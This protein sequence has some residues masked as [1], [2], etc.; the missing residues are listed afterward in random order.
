MRKKCISIILTLSMMFGSI[1]SWGLT[2]YSEE[3]PS[4]TAPATEAVP[5]DTTV[6][7][8]ETEP[9]ITETEAS[10]S[11]PVESDI[12]EDTTE[13]TD[14]DVTETPVVT[15]A[16]V[17]EPTTVTEVSDC[18]IRVAL[19]NNS[20][21]YGQNPPAFNTFDENGVPVNW[22]FEKYISENETWEPIELFSNDEAINK[23]LYKN[24]ALSFDNTVEKEQ[25]LVDEKGNKYALLRPV[26]VKYSEQDYMQL[27]DE[28]Y[29]YINTDSSVK[30]IFQ[31]ELVDENY[32]NCCIYNFYEPAFAPSVEC[33]FEAGANKV[34]LTAPHNFSI[35]SDVSGS[36]F[37]DSIEYIVDKQS[38]SVKY[39]LKN[40]NPD[41]KEEYQAETL[42]REISYSFD[43]TVPELSESVTYD[44]ETNSVLNFLSFG[45]FGN[46]ETKL[47]FKAYGGQ[48]EFL[49]SDDEDLTLNFVNLTNGNG[50]EITKVDLKATVDDAGVPV[51]NSAGQI[52]YVAYIDIMPE[53]QNAV[54]EAY[55][56]YDNN[57]S[58]A[59]KLIINKVK[60]GDQLLTLETVPVEIKIPDGFTG[61]FSSLQDE[62]SVE[63]KDNT[64]GLAEVNVYLDNSEQPSVKKTYNEKKNDDVL[65][66]TLKELSE[67]LTDGEHKFVIKAKDNSGNVE[68]EKTVD[69]FYDSVQPDVTVEKNTS[70]DKS[71]SDDKNFCT[72]GDTI[73]ITVNED[74]LS[75]CSLTING[76]KGD[77]QL[78]NGLAEILVTED[79]FKPGQENTIAVEAV[80]ISGSNDTDEYKFTY[81]NTEPEVKVNKDT[82]A[83][84]SEDINFCT[85]GD[86]VKISVNESNLKSA[87]YFVNGVKQD[88]QL[89][90]GD[91]AIKIGG[92]AYKSAEKNIIKV[93]A[94]DK[95][96]N[97][98]SAEY[99]FT[100]DDKKSDITVTLSKGDNSDANEIWYNSVDDKKIII[101]TLDDIADIKK[102]DVEVKR[103]D[104]SVWQNEN[105]E[106][107]NPY[108]VALK[109]VCGDN[110]Q[111]GQ[112]TVNVKVT[113]KAGND[114]VTEKY[115]N[116]DTIKPYVESIIF[117]TKDGTT[118][119]AREFI[120]ESFEYGYYFNTEDTLTAVVNV[121]D[122]APS[123][124]LKMMSYVLENYNT[125]KNTEGK[126]EIL[127]GKAS[128]EIPKGFKGQ[129][130]VSV[131]DNVGNT[132]EDVTPYGL[133]IDP[134][135]V[136]GS[137]ENHISFS[138]LPED[139]EY[140]DENNTPIYKTDDENNNPAVSL[141]VNVSD[142]ESGI[143]EIGYKILSSEKVLQEGTAI[144]E[145]NGSISDKSWIIDAEN[146]KDENL[147]TAVSRVF[148]FYDDGNDIQLVITMKDRAGNISELVS[149]K[150]IIDNTAPV[151]KVEFKDE[152][153]SHGEENYYKKSRKATITVTER[154]ISVEDII[155]EITNSSGSVP[156]Y[157]FKEVD[158]TCYEAEIVFNEGDYHFEVSYADFANNVATVLYSGGN[159]NDF[160]VDMTAPVVDISIAEDSKKPVEIDGKDWID[161]LNN[162]YSW[163]I[164]INEKNYSSIDFGNTFEEANFIPEITGNNGK[165]SLTVESNKLKENKGD[166]TYTIEATVKDKAG[167][168]V[169]LNPTVLHIDRNAPVIDEV[170]ADKCNVRPYGIF[171]NDNI[172]L[173]VK[174]ADGQNESGIAELK[175]IP[176]YEPDGRSF[177]GPDK[178]GYYNITIS[179]NLIEKMGYLNDE[180]S[181]EVVA[182][183]K[184][185][186]KSVID[187]DKEKHKSTYDQK[188]AAKKGGE[189]VAPCVL[190]IDK[191]D[192]L[193]YIN[194]SYGDNEDRGKGI[195]YRDILDKEMVI[196]PS[197]KHSGLNIVD[198]SVFK[199]NENGTKKKLSIPDTN[200]NY[201]SESE[202]IFEVDYVIELS[203]IFN[204]KPID[205][206]KYIVSVS[207]TDNAGNPINKT[208]E[209]NI[210]TVRPK[211]DSIDFSIKT[212]DGYESAEKYISK[213]EYGYYFKKDITV[214]VNVSD[215]D[216]SSGLWKIKDT[217]TDYSSGEG[218]VVEEEFRNVSEGNKVVFE[219]P[220]G[221]KGQISIAAFDNVGNASGVA[222]PQ[223]LIIDSPEKHASEQHIFFS[224]FEATPY[225]DANGNRLY[226]HGVVLTVTVV[227]DVSGIRQV[228]YEYNSENGGSSYSSI[229]IENTGYEVGQTLGD[230]WV[231]KKMDDNLVTEVSRTFSF[232][233]DGN[234]IWLRADMQDRSMN[235]SEDRSELFT[236]DMTAPVIS[237]VFDNP[238]GNG[239]YYS[240]NRTATVNVTERNFDAGRIIAD[241]TNSFGSTPSLSFSSN[242]ATEHTA[243][244]TFGEG[245]YT[246]SISGSD[247]ANHP[248][249]V[250][251]SG[252]NEQKFF[253]DLTDPTETDNFDQFINNLNNSFNVN[254]EMTIS[255]VEHNFQPDMVDL[256]IY[257]VPAGQSF[258]NGNRTECTSQYV[259]A[260][261]WNSSG[262]N[263]SISFTFEEDYIY[264]VSIGVTDASGRTL[265]AKN[266]PVFEIDKTVPVL[267]SPDDL[268]SIVY[269]K[270]DTKTKADP[271]V[272]NDSNIGSIN[273]EITAYQMLKN[274]VDGEIVGYDVEEHTYTEKIEGSTFT[275]NDKYFKTDG[276][277]EVKCIANDIA[278]N[279]SKQSV[280]TFIVQRDTDFLVYIPNSNKETGEGRYKFD[281]IGRRSD[282]FEDINIV[283]YI[284]AD[285]MFSVELDDNEVDEA[286]FEVNKDDKSINDVCKYD[287]IL[288]SNYISQNYGDEDAELDL[289]LNAFAYDKNA[290]SHGLPITL[291]HIHV[292][293]VKPAGDYESSMQ[294]LAWYDGFYGVNNKTLKIEGVSLDID[295]DNCEITANNDNLDFT[296]DENSHTISFT[297]GK[298]SHDVSAILRDKAGNEN[299]LAEKK[300]IYV[301]SVIDRFLALI[302]V[303]GII[304]I[305]API[306]SIIYIRK[307]RASN[308]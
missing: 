31:Q 192:P 258:N 40:N 194:L 43:R 197:D 233:A 263:H 246:F 159:E 91:T 203:T 276:I 132:Q 196:T 209:F 223:G 188:V 56:S 216:P 9:V 254:K 101:E 148:D 180:I 158:S 80:D 293:N 295:A 168:T 260:G 225:S 86:T 122:N 289:I 288:K 124:G 100:Y 68:S 13:V 231:V 285:K 67:G 7:P 97:V 193:V 85:N 21:Y 94:V 84:K 34:K 273:C 75:S 128:F 277:Y 172:T 267:Q 149:D 90:N 183:D 17:E 242:S 307:R 218:I 93:E 1:P 62:I 300:N 83:S 106:M 266:S 32:K 5:D 272:F 189:K 171:R 147:V 253:V 261:Q 206:G 46:K 95:S 28:E 154:N 264:Q 239:E 202:A 50:Q 20:L 184:F 3:I 207:V 265:A 11:A 129:V 110:L 134:P 88:K 14:T 79:K 226:D 301:G 116:V 157:E 211:V 151:I 278:G 30:Y 215:K 24:V 142:Y 103:P 165:L 294:N 81:D 77:L 29:C 57:Y 257:R 187:S 63:L 220:A 213:L 268:S 115:F 244:L 146:G 232:G 271:I 104:G 308:K 70:A 58:T 120:Q 72:D 181:F 238:A 224:G 136:H 222:T 59:K 274:D 186:N 245:D 299:F 51:R 15:D 161:P 65:T 12:I 26:K 248:A 22:G 204:N 105:K 163:K 48:N 173:Y 78:S 54:F 304:V 195:W 89:S 241:I 298:G 8:T 284:A 177:N 167:N 164:D 198:I 60:D 38:G 282:R 6:E 237:V 240:A 61:L 121:K 27:I 256:H 200:K 36:G 178:D 130:K 137:S 71:K 179:A 247:L 87:Y 251:Y 49:I 64:S 175:F 243:V 155:V 283:A 4:D 107:S 69:F 190:M 249:S 143:A 37:A 119:E 82:S 23:S 118:K 52:E 185:G 144:I 229:Q 123:S 133:V 221:F 127:N 234:D 270:K 44:E 10:E 162:E 18:Y 39:Y 139:S 214:T 73:L 262:D 153:G 259:S 138:R 291:G 156:K 45:V 217:L 111:N 228:G 236:I 296:Y 112:Y 174:A 199:E 191:K 176:D 275:L 35:K 41:N 74:N 152:N 305:G 306:A 125:D 269:T 135:S 2:S 281:S 150:F 252:G 292:D 33:R 96:G 212:A 114:S 182:I 210:D 53:I 302:A 140:K 255:V 227:D 117:N 279:S 99:E 126:T 287:T 108:E 166:G 131:V 66:F 303:G 208:A 19:K 290:S 109:T 92:D 286:Y 42:I 205:N 297:L 230:G 169:P 25:Y 280:H 160:H 235:Y 250:S 113:D 102:I 170:V 201:S 219:I 55:V 141:T 98:S 76:V 145:N 47:I 16:V